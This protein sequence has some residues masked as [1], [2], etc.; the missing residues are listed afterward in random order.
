MYLF[1]KR[2]MRGAI[3]P[4]D[5]GTMDPKL[6]QDSELIK[7]Q[8]ALEDDIVNAKRSDFMLKNMNAKDGMYTCSKCKGKKTTFYEQQ[9]RSADEPMTTFVQCLECG[10]N[11]KF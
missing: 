2:I 6:M 5:V 7:K 3:K 9:T 4:E 8:E 11:M 10:H 1:R